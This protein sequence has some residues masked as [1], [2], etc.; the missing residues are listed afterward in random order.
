MTK[1]TTIRFTD[2]EYKM[3]KK[4]SNM[5]DESITDFM[6]KAI[7]DRVEDSIDYKEA[8]AS[9]EESNEETVSREEIV[10]R[11]GFKFSD[12]YNKKN[13]ELSEDRVESL[14][15]DYLKEYDRQTYLQI[16]NKDGL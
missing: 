10:S 11:L 2:D 6:K 8:I 9:K 7:L 14:L 13:I 15:M 16:I 12:H 3:I 4:A 1:M 5:Y